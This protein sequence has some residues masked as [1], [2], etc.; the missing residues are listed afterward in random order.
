MIVRQS[1]QSQ[2]NLTGLNRKS[3]VLSVV[4]NAACLRKDLFSS[5]SSG[6]RWCRYPLSVFAYVWYYRY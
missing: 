3:A 4:S 2:L 1:L 5:F 6:Q